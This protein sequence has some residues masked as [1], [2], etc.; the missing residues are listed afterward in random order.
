MGKHTKQCHWLR[1]GNHTGQAITNPLDLFEGSVGEREF[2]CDQLEA[3]ADY[4]PNRI[5]IRRVLSAMQFL[6]IKLPVYHRDERN[7]LFPL[8]KRRAPRS[9]GIE[10]IIARMEICQID[11]EDYAQEV[12]ELLEALAG[13]NLIANPT[14]AGYLLRGFFQ[15]Y[16]RY[17]AFQRL[18]ILPLAGRV[19]TGADF[20]D[21]F[22]AVQSS[23]R[24]METPVMYLEPT[25]N[26]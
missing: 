15:G 9:S 16:R 23:R 21:L 25:A 4:L 19:L 22:D 18:T 26:S 20:A 24:M 8:L 13:D 1:H 10:K 11:D 5:D 3:I 14:A 7:G 17:L 6:R 12:V 2:V